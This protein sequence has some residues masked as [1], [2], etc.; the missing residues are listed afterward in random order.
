MLV[1]L[2]SDTHGMIRAEA[3]AALHGVELILHA[4]D[5]G[6]FAV[7]RE[8][9]G[10]APVRAVFGNTD[11]PGILGLPERVDLQLGGLAI[12]MSHGHETGSPTPDSLVRRY[13]A[14][15]IIYGHTHKPLIAHVGKTL[16][17]NPGAA[18]ARRF[19]LQPSVGLLRIE[20]GAASA[21]IVTLAVH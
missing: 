7:L 1:G 19:K 3:L 18:G 14:D 21:E 5:V 10:I 4:G 11:D 12:H 13:A 15:V 8:L 2:I 6:S 16:I 9:Q 17:V 20:N